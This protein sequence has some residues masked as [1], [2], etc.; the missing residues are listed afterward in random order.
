MLPCL[1]LQ[2]HRRGGGEL[3]WQGEGQTERLR[4][5]SETGRQVLEV[6]WDGLQGGFRAAFH[7]DVL[8]QEEAE[9]SD[10]QRRKSTAPADTRVSEAG[11]QTYLWSLSVCVD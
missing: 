6:S 3:S 2:P 11:W 8:K 10:L 7:V 4:R 5:P 1:R 9:L